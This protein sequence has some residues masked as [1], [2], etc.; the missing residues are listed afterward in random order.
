MPKLYIKYSGEKIVGYRFGD[1]SRAMALL[2][3]GGYPTEEE[4]VLAWYR[5]RKLQHELSDDSK[6]LP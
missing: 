3:D 1:S 5:E 6:S 2:V 4:A